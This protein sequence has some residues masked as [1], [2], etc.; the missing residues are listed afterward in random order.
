MTPEDG[1]VLTNDTVPFCMI[2]DATGLAQPEN[3]GVEDCF[4]VVSL[5]V[6]VHHNPRPTASPPLG[7]HTPWWFLFVLSKSSVVGV[8][9]DVYG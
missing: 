8:T 7:I 5:R 3:N 2:A 4:G 9:G 6:K 1:C